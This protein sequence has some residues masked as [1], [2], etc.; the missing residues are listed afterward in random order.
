MFKGGIQSFLI[1]FFFNFVLLTQV[2]W[3]DSDL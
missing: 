2:M 1:S 3:Y